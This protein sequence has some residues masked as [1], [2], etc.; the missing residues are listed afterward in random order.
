MVTGLAQG[1]NQCPASSL[2]H[3]SIEI[4]TILKTPQL[5][6]LWWSDNIVV[7]WGIV[8]LP[9]GYLGIFTT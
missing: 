2:K 1:Q 4:F 6:P 9:L 3:G 8:G 5:I 7:I